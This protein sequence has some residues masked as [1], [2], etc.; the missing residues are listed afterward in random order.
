MNAGSHIW[1]CGMKRNHKQTV[2]VQNKSA[3]NLADVPPIKKGC[4]KD[5]LK[6]PVKQI[7]K[8]RQKVS[9]GYKT[10]DRIKNQFTAI[11]FLLEPSKLFCVKRRLQTETVKIFVL[12]TALLIGFSLNVRWNFPNFTFYVVLFSVILAVAYGCLS[13]FYPSMNTL[14]AEVTGL[15][16]FD[17]SEYFYIEETSSSIFYII[18]PL[19]FIVIFGVGGTVIYGAVSFTPTF[20]W[21]LLYFTVVV[22]FSMLAYSQYIRFAIYLYKASHN[23]QQFENMIVPNQRELPPKLSWLIHITKISQV[24][25]FMFFIVGG[26]YIFAFAMFCFSPVYHVKIGVGLFY[27][28]WIVIFVFVVLAFPV[29]CYR[30]VADIK[31]LVAKTKHCY[32]HEILLEK[33][34]QQSPVNDI[35][36]LSI[37]IRNY[38]ISIVL[39][40]PN[41]PTGGK[42]STV[43][44]AVG[45][46]INF[47]ASIATVLEYQ[48]IRLFN[49]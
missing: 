21:C 26:S 43:F 38:C 47:A 23:D 30:K 32:I 34:L 46:I 28:L 45:V 12:A 29:I 9:A 2:V 40:T 25:N 33:Q 39:N 1:G 13:Y 19:C 27:T 24:L 35:A 44:S 6:K 31:R 49:T 4:G 8:V 20:I 22:Y 7:P 37:I 14:H 5:V 3:N 41:Y 17:K 48:G 10:L 16:P 18:F 36:R 42:V 11:S 15:H